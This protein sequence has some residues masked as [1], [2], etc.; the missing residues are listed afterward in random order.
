MYKYFF[1]F[2]AL[3]LLNG[4]AQA[5][6]WESVEKGDVQAVKTYLAKGTDVNTKN[7]DKDTPLHWA[8][9]N[10]YTEVA[11]LLI[12]K[13]ADVNAKNEDGHT[14]LHWAAR[15]GYT[16]VAKLLIDKGADL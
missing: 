1:I 13:G 3:L 15:N 11:K 14:P 12:D 6:I 7:K 8:A 10:G 9:R 5:D 2:A 4:Q 16:E